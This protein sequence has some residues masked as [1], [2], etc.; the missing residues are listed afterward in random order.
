M[1]LNTYERS[2]TFPDSYGGLTHSCVVFNKNF[3]NVSYCAKCL[4]FSCI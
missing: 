1:G 2:F 3:M 4:G